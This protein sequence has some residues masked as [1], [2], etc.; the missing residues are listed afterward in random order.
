MAAQLSEASLG[1]LFLFLLVILVFLILLADHRAVTHNARLLKKMQED[2]EA[3]KK[4]EK[5]V[6]SSR[7]H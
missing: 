2:P 5:N 7:G 3:A 1:V 4:E 6:Y